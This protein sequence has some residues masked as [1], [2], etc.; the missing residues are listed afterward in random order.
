MSDES[1]LLRMLSEHPDD[2]AARLVYADWLEG[3]GA[4]AKARLLRL[5]CELAATPIS[6]AALV[7]RS[8]ALLGCSRGL[9]GAW[10]AE[11]SYPRLAGTCWGTRDH[12]GVP[13]IVGFLAAG[14]LVYR[15]ANEQTGG[16]WGQVGCAVR[17]DI[18]GYSEHVGACV[19]GGMRGTA[20][21]PNSG[22]W[23]WAFVQI[24][25]RFLDPASA[26]PE[27][28]PEPMDTDYRTGG[29]RQDDR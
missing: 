16:S 28:G 1:T 10:V 7:T 26:F 11:V 9:D 12:Q 20:R 27:L 24:E 29:T 4:E 18:N 22:T 19:A 23:N 21:N 13:Y 6:D 17:F 2:L 8:R 14:Q 15:R 25:P 5:H 3:Q